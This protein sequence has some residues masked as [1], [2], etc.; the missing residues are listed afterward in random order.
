MCQKTIAPH[1]PAH[2]DSQWQKTIPAYKKTRYRTDYEA[3]AG[4]QKTRV[5]SASF[6]GDTPK[7]NRLIEANYLQTLCR[8]LILPSNILAIRKLLKSALATCGM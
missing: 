2:E 7:R 8:V 3:M 4:L 1:Y 6:E 5:A